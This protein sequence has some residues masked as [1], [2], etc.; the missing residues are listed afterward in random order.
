MLTNLM[1][2][3]GKFAPKI[4]IETLTLNLPGG[5]YLR[6]E[7]IGVKLKFAGQQVG[8]D[9]VFENA[10]AADGTTT[11]TRIAARNLTAAFGDGTTQYVT[12]SD[13]TGFFLVNATGIAGRIA[14][15]VTVSVPGV[16]DVRIAA[17]P[18]TVIVP[19]PEG[20]SYL[21][22]IFAHG[23]SAESVE[24]SLRDAYRCLQWEIDKELAVVSGRPRR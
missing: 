15:S 24:R 21:G 5:P 11:I 10:T 1:E 13:G 6:V 20:R 17:K 8:G 7:G 14:G 23:S 18:D 9:F 16:D 12:L 19:L 2:R 4:Q 22:F 3:L